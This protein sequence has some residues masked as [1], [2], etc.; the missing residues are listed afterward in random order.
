MHPIPQNPP[1]LG[2]KDEGFQGQGGRRMYSVATMNTVGTRRKIGKGNI[3]SYLL[4]FTSSSLVSAGKSN[5]WCQELGYSDLQGE[6]LPC[7]KGTVKRSVLIKSADF[8]W[9]ENPS[10]PTLRNVS[11]DM[12]HGEK[13]AVCGEV[14]SGKSTLLAAILGEVPLTQGTRQL[15]CLGRALLRR[16]RILVLDEATA[17]IDNATDLILQKTIR[18]EFSD[19]TVIIVAHRIP[20]VMDCTMVLAISDGKLVEY[21]EPTKLMKKE[22]SVF[23][24]LVKE[25]WSH[26]HAAE[27]H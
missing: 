25:Y 27:S 11:L 23:R 5:V 14:D 16:S 2:S 9:E 12:R 21:D 6:D 10:K 3:I 22:G 17:S 7:N 4:S 13:V 20:A 24:Q 26:L 8:S 1:W 18:T 15:F 19:C